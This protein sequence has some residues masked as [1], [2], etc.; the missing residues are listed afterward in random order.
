MKSSCK[1]GYREEGALAM[2]GYKPGPGLSIRRPG[3]RLC[4]IRPR[5]FVDT[6]NGPTEHIRSGVPSS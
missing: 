4:P 5:S 1:R 6:S 2:A 3:V